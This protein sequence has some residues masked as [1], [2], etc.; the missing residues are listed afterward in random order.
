MSQ[1]TVIPIN[2]ND[3]AT[4]EMKERM[5]IHSKSVEKLIGDFSQSTLDKTELKSDMFL[6]IYLILT[7]WMMN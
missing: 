4:P 5:T 1:S 6:E 2:T 7:H 3:L